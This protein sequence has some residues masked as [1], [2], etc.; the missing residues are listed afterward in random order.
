MKKYSGFLLIIL[1]LSVIFIGYVSARS[2]SPADSKRYA[3]SISLV[4]Y[5]HVTKSEIAIGK[6]ILIHSSNFFN[7][8]GNNIFGSSPSTWNQIIGNK[9]LQPFLNPKDP[10]DHQ[11]QMSDNVV[12][13]YCPT[14][15]D[16][17]KPTVT[18]SFLNENGNVNEYI[19]DK[20]NVKVDNPFKPASIPKRECYSTKNK[21]SK[22]EC[23]P[24][25]YHNNLSFVPV[26]NVYVNYYTAEYK[27]D[28]VYKRGK[29]TFFKVNFNGIKQEIDNYFNKVIV[30]P[31]LDNRNNQ[32]KALDDYI[33]NR[34]F[35]SIFSINN[36]FNT[37][38]DT[39]NLN[40]YYLKVEALELRDGNKTNFKIGS[41]YI[42]TIEA[43]QAECSYTNPVNGPRKPCPYILKGGTYYYYETVQGTKKYSS[44]TECAK[45]CRKT[46]GGACSVTPD[47]VIC[48][49]NKKNWFQLTDYMGYDKDKS[50]VS[51]IRN[52][53]R[54]FRRVLAGET[55]LVKANSYNKDIIGNYCNEDR[56]SF[57]IRDN[58]DNCIPGKFERYI[59]PN[60]NESI[61]G[62]TKNNKYNF[63]NKCSSGDV[64]S[65]VPNGVRFYYLN[66]N[67]PSQCQDVKVCGP[68]STLKCAEN[69]CDSASA[70][71]TDL[72]GTPRE[73]KKKCII[74]TCNY[75][76]TK[77]E[78]I[79][80][81]NSINNNNSTCGIDSNGKSIFNGK[82]NVLD[83]QYINEFDK[84]KKNIPF[85]MRKYI[86]VECNNDTKAEV[87]MKSSNY[88]QGYPINS[89]SLLTTDTK[90][91]F[92]FDYQQWTFDFATVHS[93][94]LDNRR[95]LLYIYNTFNN[96]Q[97]IDT[98]SKIKDY[99]V[100]VSSLVGIYKNN[101]ITIET[102]PYQD[103]A[104]ALRYG[105]EDYNWFG[106]VD[107]NKYFWKVNSDTSHTQ[108]EVVLGK[109]VVTVNDKKAYDEFLKDNKVSVTEIA[110]TDRIKLTMNNNQVELPVNRY[111]A[112]NQY[113]INYLPAT[114]CVDMN[115]DGTWSYTDS[116]NNCK[117]GQQ[118]SN[119]FF[120]SYN[121]TPKAR[122][123]NIITNLKVK[124][125]NNQNFLNV[126]DKCEY[127]VDENNGQCEISIEPINCAKM[128]HQRLLNGN[129]KIVINVIGKNY[130]KTID[131]YSLNYSN[132]YPS[133]E[134]KINI[135]NLN[136]NYNK[137]AYTKIEA[138]VSYKE[139]GSFKCSRNIEVIPSGSCYLQTE[140]G[141]RENVYKINTSISGWSKNIEINGNGILMKF[142]D[143]I[144]LK[145]DRN[146]NL[147]VEGILE[148]N[149]EKISCGR[150]GIDFGTCFCTIP[151]NERANQEKINEYCAKNYKNDTAGF[152]SETI[153]RRRCGICYDTLN[154]ND[155]MDTV[156]K[157]YC[158]NSKR[159]GFSSDEAC[160][161]RCHREKSNIIFRQISNTDPFPY[162]VNSTKSFL[163]SNGRTYRPIGSNWIRYHKYI[164]EDNDDRTSITGAYAG[165]EVEYVVDL[166]PKSMKMIRND[167]YNRNYKYTGYDRRKNDKITGPFYSRFIHENPNTSILFSVKK[168]PVVIGG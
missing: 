143:S 2:F 64:Q 125:D 162:S 97:S 41:E 159:Y 149:G 156:I 62:T 25:Y 16:I 99:T 78:I 66:I 26:V 110:S 131:K 52:Y 135:F 146:E 79:I 111:N 105:K 130:N 57:C 144:T 94:D 28:Y 92:R 71:S 138:S 129:Y 113:I 55:Y 147:R 70:T 126:N 141:E 23:I 77:S 109:K 73:R 87:K 166:T 7:D 160:Y 120:V 103:E 115:G 121:A 161:N 1:F 106:K 164:T 67:K 101:H 140:K 150:E 108:N 96:L 83:Y 72:K 167:N 86:I 124:Y 90:C 17:P 36:H 24:S 154:G 35:T 139:G 5:N 51:G 47:E 81:Q 82:Y 95:K 44:L 84:K 104:F 122:P 34:I 11:Y 100:S 53:A 68:N 88:P 63:S 8:R 38:I 136:P 61:V 40:M 4:E 112:I 75:K 128:D 91:T 65:N 80:G 114:K 9:D 39:S 21:N 145:K 76:E 45:N 137:Y 157:N 168:E 85:D 31:E 119:D 132:T 37:N 148:R 142:N 165:I 155:E 89:Q 93:K 20:V 48:I 49:Y 50:M 133:V 27:L 74:D 30:L 127:L 42:R 134:S 158:E 12:S 22:T 60:L 123:H 19:S 58:S 13:P 152:E 153:C 118:K 107:Y 56:S 14:C 10:V 163:S 29:R 33:N 117:V 98:P 43:I 59:G 3:Y 69:Y 6:P 46:Y 15:K 151:E 18:E 116:G 32:N 54:L 102:L